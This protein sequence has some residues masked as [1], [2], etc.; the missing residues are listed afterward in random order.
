[1]IS[2]NNSKISYDFKSFRS[3]L[4]HFYGAYNLL[5]SKLDTMQSLCAIECKRHGGFLH[6]FFLKERTKAYEFEMT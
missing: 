5:F 6:L 1:M 3:H 4:K 2:V